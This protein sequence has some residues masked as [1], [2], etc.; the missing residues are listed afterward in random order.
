MQPSKPSLTISSPDM[1]R[2]PL[3]IVINRASGAQAHDERIETLKRIFTDAGRE[4]EFLIVKDASQ[5]SAQAQRAV[6]LALERHGIVVAA[7]GDG[8]LNAVAQE[9]IQH[10]CPFGVLPQGTF[11]YFGRVHGIS[12]DTESA[13]RALLRARMEPVQLGFVNG[14]IFL[15]NASLGLYPQLL[16]DREAFKQKLGRSRIV[17][18]FS[19]LMTLLRGHRQLTLEI[20]TASG[21][22]TLRTPTLFI[23]NNPLQFERLG[24][25]DSAAALERGQLAAV[26]MNPIGSLAM[27]G[28]ALRGALGQLGEA[29]KL[30]HL[31]FRRMTVRL[32]GK[33]RI[34]LATDG[35][36][37]WMKFPLTFEVAPHAL[38]LLVPLPEDRV[39][40]E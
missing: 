17:A 5:I 13:A 28:L 14:K 2:A 33:R 4:H 19:G 36:I 38:Q 11:N 29:E 1:S 26:A 18:L 7:G 12:Q 22:R 16:E 40:V 8:T 3:F 37:Q 32:R 35:E 6:K 25:E 39:N 15:V 30:M 10:D 34:K 9:T 24:L 27:L 23:G 20:E 21:S 31:T